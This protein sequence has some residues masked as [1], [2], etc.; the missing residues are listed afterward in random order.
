MMNHWWWTF[1]V[2][3][4]CCSWHLDGSLGSLCQIWKSRVGLDSSL[5]WPGRPHLPR[6]LRA[7]PRHGLQPA[8]CRQDGCVANCCWMKYEI[9]KFSILALSGALARVYR[10]N[11]ILIDFISRPLFQTCIYILS[12]FTFIQFSTYKTEPGNVLH[13]SSLI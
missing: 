11:F 1:L 5:L 8:C 10:I 4:R 9:D 13:F 7:Q 3:G 12:L 6:H 2:T